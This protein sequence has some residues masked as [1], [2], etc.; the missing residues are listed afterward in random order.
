MLKRV[1]GHPY[2]WLR[3]KI[4]S[5]GGTK[6]ESVL[7]LRK[8]LRAPGGVR[9]GTL[10]YGKQER[11]RA[12]LFSGRFQGSCTG[13]RERERCFGNDGP[14]KNVC[15]HSSDERAG[16][17]GEHHPEQAHH[18]RVHVEIFADAAADAAELGVDS[19]ARQAPREP[20]R[21][22]APAA[23]TTKI[24]GIG[25][26]TLA[27][28]AHHVSHLLAGMEAW[29]NYT[30]G[31]ARLASGAKCNGKTKKAIHLVGSCIT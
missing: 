21:P 30:A 22:L 19:R 18:G 24:R 27:V 11:R 17:Y 14:G 20:C 26:V 9:R 4:A 29:R 7:W 13:S 3:L 25:N 10:S 2:R 28:G 15:Q 23:L 6:I 16:N 12:S 1:A 5:Y 31:A 8:S